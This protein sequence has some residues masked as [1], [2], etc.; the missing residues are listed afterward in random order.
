MTRTCSEEGCNNHIRPFNRS[1][2]CT[3]CQR[4]IV[5]TV[6]PILSDAFD[7]DVSPET[8]ARIATGVKY[9]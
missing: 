1:G 6:A 8:I 2:V 7:R 5:A 9:D 4:G 3:E